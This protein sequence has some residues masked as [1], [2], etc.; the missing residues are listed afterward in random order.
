[1]DSFLS[2]GCLQVGEC[3]DINWNS[4][5]GL[6]FH[7]PTVPL[8]AIHYSNL[9]QSVVWFLCSYQRSRVPG[10]PLQVDNKTD[11]G[12]FRTC[13]SCSETYPCN[14]SETPMYV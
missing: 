2:Q 7:Y 11:N 8:E 13:V 6:P 5:S 4:N 14:H 1:M 9:R 3:N 10:F 12:E